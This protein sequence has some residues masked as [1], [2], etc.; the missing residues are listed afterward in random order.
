MAAMEKLLEEGDYTRAKK[1]NQRQDGRIFTCVLAWF[2]SDFSWYQLY[3]ERL[4][5][6]WDRMADCRRIVCGCTCDCGACM[7]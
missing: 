2:N 6:C 1:E 5:R 4:E 3:H 7:Q